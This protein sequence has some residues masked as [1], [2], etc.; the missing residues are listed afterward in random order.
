MPSVTEVAAVLPPAPTIWENE[1]ALP[2]ALISTEAASPRQLRAAVIASVAS[3]LV[4]FAAAPLAGVQLRPLPAFIPAYEAVLITIDLITAVLLFGQFAQL[5]S[6]AMLALGAGYMFD[7]L[8]IVPHALS[9]P[10]LI[11]PTGWLGAGPQT[12]A[13]LYFFWHGGFPLFVTAYAVLSRSDGRSGQRRLGVG[14]AVLIGAAVVGLAVLLALLAT[15]GESLLPTVMVANTDAPVQK[16]AAA[17]VWSITA[18]ALLV[19]LIERPYSVLNL[20]LIV[21]MIAWLADI[22][23]SAVLDVGRF[24]L[25]FYAGRLY[26]LLAASFV[27][28]VLL[29]ETTT[30]HRQLAEAGSLLRQHAR[31]LDAR[32]RQRTAELGRTNRQLNAIIEAAPLSIFMLDPAGNVLLWTASAERLFGYTAEEATGGPPPYLDADELKVWREAFARTVAEASSGSNETQRRCRDGTVINLSVTWAPVVDE[33]GTLLGVMYALANVTERRKLESQL[34]Q[35]Q[36][37]EALGNLTGGLAHDFNNHLGVIILNLDVLRERVAGDAEAGEAIDDASGAAL[38]GAELIRRLLAFARRQ[39]LEPQRTDVNHLVGET[40]KLLERTL[41]EHITISLDLKEGLWPSVID[42]TQ[43]ESSLANLANNARDAMPNGGQLHIATDNRQLDE[44]YAAQHADVTPGDYA[45]VEVGDTGGGMPPEVLAQVFEPFFTT[46]PAG[47]GTG[48]GLSM[49]YG[50]IKQ[51][52]GHIN[53][54]SEVGVGTTVRLYLP[55]AVAAA[56]PAAADVSLAATIVRGSETILAV[57]DNPSLRR[58]V[59]RQL[60]ELGYHVI[61][62]DSA[63]AAINVLE[64]RPVDLVFSDVVMPGGSG[65][66]DLTAVVDSRWPGT[67]VVLTSGF[68]AATTRGDQQ[69]AG[70]AQLLT[71]PYRREDIARVV[72]RALDDRHAG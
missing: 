3:V 13:W 31:D 34:R 10:G 60:T 29:V 64:V 69:R 16:I 9:F 27:L 62:A 52:G 63:Q 61:E 54:Y 68:P 15:R 43:L 30:L 6:A 65:G 53:V 50:F 42:P 24:D 26:G 41:G 46:K 32:V 38:R 44:D 36:K 57:E 71:K 18:A 20:W 19:L 22:A 72:R 40:A 47:K 51:T 37:M 45:M 48:L 7:A 1:P 59:V 14:H 12:T 2:R 39:P 35:A 56:T 8:L 23:L 4:L 49:V 25:G 28:A 66:Y 5:R 11:T 33:D 58:I 21:V 70:N 67:P 55:R 17:V